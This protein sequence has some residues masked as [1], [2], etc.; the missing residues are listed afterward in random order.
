M[1]PPTGDVTSPINVFSVPDHS[2]AFRPPAAKPAPSNPA[3]SACDSLDGSPKY[4]AESAHS[5]A[6]S[7]AA[8]TVPSVTNPG[9]TMP[10]AIV[11]ATAVPT[12]SAPTRF[13]V[14]AMITAGN[15]RS[16]RVE[17]TVAIEF[18]ASVQPLANSN[19]YAS[20][21]TTM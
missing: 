11:F 2:S 3:T 9:F 12:T 18:G 7:T 1:N 15:G 17:T 19:R 4:W 8:A 16:T 14:P 21:R 10:D 20:T 13:S 5:V 6:A